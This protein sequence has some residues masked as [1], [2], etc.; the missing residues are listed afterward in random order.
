MEPVFSLL[1]TICFQVPP[2]VDLLLIVLLFTAKFSLQS[3]FQGYYHMLFYARGFF[4]F[5]FSF[6]L[7]ASACQTEKKFCASLVFLGPLF[8][9]VPLVFQQHLCCRSAFLWWP[10]RVLLL[11]F[12][13]ALFKLILDYKHDVCCR[14]WKFCNC[15]CMFSSIK[16]CFLCSIL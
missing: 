5:S 10:L 13:G 9:L 15:K 14:M 7:Q 8:L 11:F 6:L 3:H 1:T 16:S 2:Q 4:F 12:V